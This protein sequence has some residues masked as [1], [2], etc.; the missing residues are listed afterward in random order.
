M[1]FELST[2]DF[3]NAPTFPQPW[4]EIFAFSY[5]PNTHDDMRKRIATAFDQFLDVSTK[6]DEE[7]ALISR[8]LGIDIAIDLSG[9]TQDGRTGVFSYRAAPIQLSYIGYLGTMGADYY[10][11]LVADLT[12]IPVKSQAYYKE[13]IVYLPSYQDH[14]DEARL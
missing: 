6:S 3:Y 11:Y 13:K 12:I 10:D 7:I 14:A 8:E 9:L 2:H 4:F 5:G 1:S